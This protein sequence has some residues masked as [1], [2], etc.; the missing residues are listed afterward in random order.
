MTGATVGGA[1]AA[2][3]DSAVASPVTRI[4]SSKKSILDTR[5][6]PG[7]VPR[8]IAL[9]FLATRAG[10]T[11]VEFVAMAESASRSP[12]PIVLAAF[13]CRVSAGSKPLLSKRAISNNL[14]R[15]SFQLCRS[16]SAGSA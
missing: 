5:L 16:A 6:T 2:A 10:R 3:V 4:A 12:P 11:I 1:D 13:G 15:A 7:R 14:A 8:P 9:P